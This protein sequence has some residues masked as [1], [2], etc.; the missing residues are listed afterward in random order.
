MQDNLF[1]LSII[2][3]ILSLLRGVETLE[4]VLK[5]KELNCDLI[6]VNVIT[7]A[8]LNSEVVAFIEN[9]TKVTND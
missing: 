6:Q 1:N 8:L 9:H 5:L 7:K 4:Q 3:A 2:E